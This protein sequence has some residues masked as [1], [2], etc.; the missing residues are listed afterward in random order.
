MGIGA[1]ASATG[2]GPEMAGQAR[3]ME[4]GGHTKL[5]R[6]GGGDLCA[7]TLLF[8][9]GNGA[10]NTVRGAKTGGAAGRLSGATSRTAVRLGTSVQELPAAHISSVRLKGASQIS[11]GYCVII[12]RPLRWDGRINLPTMHTVA[13]FLAKGT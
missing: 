3:L 12:D 2:T 9:P 6:V 1:T 13:S 8:R 11:N 4:P 10:N 5:P 7:R